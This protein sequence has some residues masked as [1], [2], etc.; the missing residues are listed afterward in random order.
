MSK[1]N[2][3]PW[4]EELRKR[5]NYVLIFYAVITVIAGIVILILIH[6]ILQSIINQKTADQDYLNQQLEANRG[7]IKVVEDIDQK[8]S[9]LISRVKI[10]QSL[11]KDRSLL[12]R[13]FDAL[14]KYTPD[15]IVL[16]EVSRSDN[17]ITLS[18]TSRSNSAISFFMRNIGQLNWVESAKL[19]NVQDQSKNN[20]L[21]SFSITLTEKTDKPDKPDKPDN[22]NAKVP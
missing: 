4:R 11:Q 7:L 2:L 17:L 14:A 10:I 13:L 20:N 9:Q 18:G 3:L 16:T 22:T 12:V 19:T 6:L 5:N 21:L 8:R 15:E 1:I